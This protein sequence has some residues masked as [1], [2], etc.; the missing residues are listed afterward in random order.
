MERISSSQ[1]FFGHPRIESA[2]TASTTAA[3][4]PESRPRDARRVR[5]AV[6][7]GNDLDVVMPIASIERVLD[8][9]VRKVDA[10]VEVRQVVFARPL[11]NLARVPVRPAVA[12][13]PPAVVLLQPR[14]VL[15]L[16]F[17]FE[18]DAADVGALIPKP[19]FLAQVRAIQL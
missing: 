14:L 10:L 12:V 1:Q 17:L 2:S 4:A 15:A 7:L 5:A 19:F 3:V 16:Q 6:V 18:D 8:P 9:K 11:L 13:G